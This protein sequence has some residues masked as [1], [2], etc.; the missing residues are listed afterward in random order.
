MPRILEMKVI[1]DEL[2]VRVPRLVQDQGSVSLYTAEELSNWKAAYRVSVA[3]A[4]R[5]LFESQ[6]I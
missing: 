1:D 5:K 4:I 3:E 6:E 2:W